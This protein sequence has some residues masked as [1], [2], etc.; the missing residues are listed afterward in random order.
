[1]FYFDPMYFVFLAP[2]LLLS[3]WASAK[4]KTAFSKFSR[5]GNTA[6]LSGAEAAAH[7]LQSQGLR[8]VRSSEEAKRMGNA[9]AITGVKGF[10]SDHYDPRAKVLRLSPQVFQGRSLSSVG[11]ACH[12]AGHAL[13]HAHGYAPLGL[14][15]ALVPVASFG[16]WLSFPLILL[17][18]I[19]NVAGLIW[20]GIA[21]FSLIVA[22]QLITLPVEY[23]ASKR[24]KLALAD[25]RITRS[26]EEDRGVA[27]VLDAAALTYVAAA[28]SAVLT[29]LYYLFILSQG[30][31]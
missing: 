23:D 4:T 11:V 25:L 20:V 26:Q 3:I 21:A 24:A 13:Q 10:L 5:V 19:L 27:Q 16:S 2:A 22:F 1:M 18:F 30:R 6:G 28:L 7:M 12:E 14:R 31:D 8:V 29:L 17:G 15:T 9:V